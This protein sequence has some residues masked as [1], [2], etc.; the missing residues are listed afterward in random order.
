PDLPFPVQRLV[1]HV[2]FQRF[3]MDG[4]TEDL[5]FPTLKM[6][7]P[8]RPRPGSLLL[9][10]ESTSSSG[11]KIWLISS[12]SSRCWMELSSP[13]LPSERWAA[14]VYLFMAVVSI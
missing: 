13:C 1:D 5:V 14:S 11:P 7:V 8:A 9:L 2:F 12:S 6:A 10:H 3:R 4:R